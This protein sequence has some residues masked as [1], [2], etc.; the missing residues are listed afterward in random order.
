MKKFRRSLFSCTGLTLALVQTGWMK[1]IVTTVALP[2]HATTSQSDRY[3]GYAN[4]DST[5]PFLRKWKSVA[6]KIPGTDEFKD[7][8]HHS[9]Q[10]QNIEN[11]IRLTGI[12][13]GIGPTEPAHV[14]YSC[15]VDTYFDT[16][17]YPSPPLYGDGLI[18]TPVVSPEEIILTFS[19]LLKDGFENFRI[20][21]SFSCDLL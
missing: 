15:M 20:P 12:S 18:S 11:T 17:K 6:T 19:I 16:E 3:A 10:L 5:Y 8:P 13:E 7:G 4:V 14:Q 2:T 9:V 1:P 21:S